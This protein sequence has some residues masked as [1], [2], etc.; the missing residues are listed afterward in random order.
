[1]MSVK[2]LLYLLKNILDQCQSL[3]L[4]TSLLLSSTFFSFTFPPL[5]APF[6]SFTTARKTAVGSVCEI[7]T[8]TRYLMFACT[9][10]FRFYLSPHTLFGCTCV[11]G[12]WLSTLGEFQ[13]LLLCLLLQSR[14]C[15]FIS[16]ISSCLSLPLS[17]LWVPELS[18]L[19]SPQQ[20]PG[21]TIGDPPRLSL[22]I[23]LP[24]SEE[25]LCYRAWALASSAAA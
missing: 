12:P 13:T 2:H 4:I 20:D 9:T 11:L 24:E 14:H 5:S 3:I 1:M 16:V 8:H 18:L 17:R 15:S 10:L 21:Q 22:L 23:L 6:L 7:N 25:A 19:D